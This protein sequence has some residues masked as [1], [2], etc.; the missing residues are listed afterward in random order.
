MIRILWE[1][2]EENLVSFD[3]IR[4]SIEKSRDRLRVLANMVLTASGLLLSSCFVFI[5]LLLDKFSGTQVVLL[6]ISFTVSALLFLFSAVFSIISSLLRP[7]YTI[8]TELKFVDDLLKL[9]EREVR[10]F[11]IAFVLLLLGLVGIFFSIIATSFVL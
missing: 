3:T 8:V 5:V 9:F 2:H 6:R 1:K 4:D 7:R 11:T 10:L